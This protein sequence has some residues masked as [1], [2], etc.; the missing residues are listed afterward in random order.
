[1]AKKLTKRQQIVNDVKEIL[2]N[3][4]LDLMKRII[5]L[6]EE[7]RE[8]VATKLQKWDKTPEIE[9]LLEKLPD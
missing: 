7:D 3:K 1:M 5:A 6:S 9:A 4:G 2:E 8:W